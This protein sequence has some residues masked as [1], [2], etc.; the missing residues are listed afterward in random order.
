MITCPLFFLLWWPAVPAVP[1]AYCLP[2]PARQ[3]VSGELS[4]CMSRADTTFV[5]ASLNRVRRKCPK[6]LTTYIELAKK[7]KIGSHGTVLLYIPGLWQELC[8]AE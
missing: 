5:H 6:Y 3:S 7:K 2:L 8:A 1:A 4:I